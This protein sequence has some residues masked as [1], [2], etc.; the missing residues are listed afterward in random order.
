MKSQCARGFVNN[1]LPSDTA[2]QVLYR[3]AVPRHRDQ[4]H[5]P[6]R[7]GGTKSRRTDKVKGLGLGSAFLKK[8]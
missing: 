3:Q 5:P 8:V 4:E 1:L 2:R 6:H 7:H